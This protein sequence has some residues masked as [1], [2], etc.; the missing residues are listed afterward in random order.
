M[1]GGQVSC[2]SGLPHAA[3]LPVGEW[4]HLPHWTSPAGCPLP[5]SPPFLYSPWDVEIRRRIECGNVDSGLRCSYAL[6]PPTFMCCTRWR[7]AHLTRIHRLRYHHSP[8]RSTALPATPAPPERQT[9]GVAHAPFTAGWLLCPAR[10]RPRGELDGPTAR[11][12]PRRAFPGGRFPLGGTG[13]ITALAWTCCMAFVGIPR[14][15][16]FAATYSPHYGFLPLPWHQP[17]HL[18]L[19]LPA[20]EEPTSNII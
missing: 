3:P 6:P 8:P 13:F 2:S 17:L 18:A 15:R 19:L 10:H 14:L 20:R 5:P 11:P 7:F 4:V 9:L 1:N 12:F 16:C